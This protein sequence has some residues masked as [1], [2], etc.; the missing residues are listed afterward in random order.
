ML[1]PDYNTELTCNAMLKWTEMNGIE[2][3]IAPGKRR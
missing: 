2:W 3:H 1:I